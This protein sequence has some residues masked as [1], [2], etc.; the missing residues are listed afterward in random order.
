M[1]HSK[2]KTVLIITGPTASGKTT[3]AIQLAK[4]FQTEII[5]ADSRQCYKELDI[6]VARP[7]PEELQQVKHHFIASHSIKEEITAAGFEKFAL[8]KT[9]EL[10]RKHDIVVIVGGTGLYIKAFCEGLDEIPEADP[11]IRQRIIDNY[12]EKG[13]EWLQQEIREKDPAFYEAGEIKNPQRVM[14][15]L[16]VVESTGRSILDFRKGKKV[17]RPFNIIK[18]GL[19]LPKEELSRNIDARV[20][21]MIKKGLL[22]EVK[23]L[24][25]C[26]DMNALQTVGYTEIF[27]HLDGKISL[28]K[29]IEDIKTH[30]RQYAK[31]QLT[32]FRKDKDIKWF[33]PGEL[34]DILSYVESVKS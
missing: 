7:S 22:Q 34:E 16:E 32:W 3:V 14:R 1:K 31:R 11:A 21:G 19:E 24:I 12:G 5:S 25:H 4:H 28:E 18:I 9:K 10:F 13:M 20:D 33:K 23:A 17:K 8:E 15:A 27:G 30:T 26:R 2:Q 29:A 6:G